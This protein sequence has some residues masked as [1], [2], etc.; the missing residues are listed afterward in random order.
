MTTD[1]LAAKIQVRRVLPTD[2]MSSYT[3][4]VS[5]VLVRSDRAFRQD[6]NLQRMMRQDPD[7]MHAISV[8]EAA[9]ADMAWRIRPEDESDL[10]HR[11]RCMAIQKA[12]DAIPGL[13]QMRRHIAK[14][15]WYGIGSTYQHWAKLPR[16]VTAEVVD[17]AVQVE[18]GAT[19]PAAT[20]SVTVS[21]IRFDPMPHDGIRF[22]ADGRMV[23]LVNMRSDRFRKEDGYERVT[24]DG[25]TGVIIPEDQRTAWV[26]AVWN[27]DAADSLDYTSAER[28]YAGHGMRSQVWDAWL[29]KQLLNQLADSYAE[30]LA[31]GT[32]V[33]VH[34][35]SQQ[36]EA[37]IQNVINTLGQSSGV[38]IPSTLI[39]D[40]GSI[41]SILKVFEAT[42][43]GNQILREMANDAGEKLKLMILAQTL[44]TETAATGLGSGV[45][46]VHQD[47]FR[48]QLRYDISVT[49]EALTR[50]LVGPMWRIN[51]P[52]DP[53]V[54]QF[55]SQIRED[56]EDI[57]KTVETA[58]RL[59][60][61]GVTLAMNDV[62]EKAGFREPQADE[63]TIGGPGAV[64]SPV[65]DL[66]NGLEDRDLA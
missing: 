10:G 27:T 49:D 43:T 34:D 2:L 50:D 59:T 62:R 13:A 8:R 9:G 54:P 65:D 16:P 45:A 32:V 66:L 63:P 61:M 44:T 23:L 29:R 47:T 35:G 6:R 17:D 33:G 24:T 42:G 36:G 1:Q 40:N 57:D 52:D 53:R 26:L 11:A 31:R 20:A 15:V 60:G 18:S 7:I 19:A 3:D 48:T 5:G 14:C 41:D 37:A 38:T 30:R 22:T 12:I 46:E 25:G 4:A 21:P 58:E 51:F 39:Q 64:N 56:E 55:V 28:V